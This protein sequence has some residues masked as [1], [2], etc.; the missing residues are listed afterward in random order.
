MKLCVSV[1]C[2]VTAAAH[3][4]AGEAKGKEKTE[5]KIKGPPL[6]VFFLF[7]SCAYDKEL[8]MFFSAQSEHTFT[9]NSI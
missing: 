6:P 9:K 8:K 4:V 5:D 2:S 7:F 3:N 1:C